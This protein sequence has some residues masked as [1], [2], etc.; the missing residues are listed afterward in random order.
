MAREGHA[1]RI[2]AKLGR[3][4]AGPRHRLG[5]VLEEGREANLRYLAIVGNHHHETGLG[6]GPP[7]EGVSISVALDPAP[8]VPPDQHR[9]LGLA[10]IGRGPDI[11]RLAV[12]AEGNRRR[13][14]LCSPATAHEAVDKREHLGWRNQGVGRPAS[15]N[16]DKDGK[17]YSLPHQ[18]PYRAVVFAPISSALTPGAIST[19]L[20]GEP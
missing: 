8:A 11:E 9:M 5:A 2:A 10:P 18:L 6:E 15:K 16:D 19:S 13:D 1:L 14:A 4:V 20:N 3:V 7:G 12:R 17:R